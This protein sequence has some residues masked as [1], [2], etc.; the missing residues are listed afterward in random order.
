MVFIVNQWTSRSPTTVQV[1]SNCD[2]VSL[3]LNGTMVSTRSPDAGTILLHPTFDFDLGS[4]TAGTLEADCL[5]SGVKKAMFT[6][7]T[8]GAATAIRLRAEGPR[9]RQI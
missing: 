8:P 9:C 5:M 3:Y 7:Q 6:S 2:Q 1:Y 4:F